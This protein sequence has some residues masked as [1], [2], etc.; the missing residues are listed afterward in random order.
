MC[1]LAGIK[2]VFKYVMT[3]NRMALKMMLYIRAQERDLKGQNITKETVIE[4]VQDLLELNEKLFPFSKPPIEEYEK[5][6]LLQLAE[7]IVTDANFETG[8]D[9]LK[10]LKAIIKINTYPQL[11]EVIKVKMQHGD[12][13]KIGVLLLA[14]SHYF[15]SIKDD[16]P[17][18]ISYTET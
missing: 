3:D 15:D 16:L 2:N 10:N 7:K 18:D 11:K 12:F 14:F 17:E 4:H 6:G 13:M 9:N 8:G 1:E 5:L